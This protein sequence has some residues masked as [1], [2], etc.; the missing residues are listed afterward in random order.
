MGNVLAINTTVDG[1]FFATRTSE[2]GVVV[3][4]RNSS[5]VPGFMAIGK[6]Q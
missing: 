6:V 5:Q 3:A 1:N 4:G 2:L